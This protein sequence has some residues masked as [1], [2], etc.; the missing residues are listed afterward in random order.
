MITCDVAQEKLAET[1]AEALKEDDELRQHVESCEACSHVLESLQ[2]LDQELAQTPVV[3]APDDVVAKTLDAVREAAKKDTPTRKPVLPRRRIAGALAASVAII[4]AVGVTS[5]VMRSTNDMYAF[6]AP[7]DTAKTSTGS[8]G[9]S[10]LQ[11]RTSGGSKPDQESTPGRKV[12]IVRGLEAQSK[13]ATESAQGEFS[14]LAQAGPKPAFGDHSSADAPAESTVR[15]QGARAFNKNLER[16]YSA[17]EA[18]ANRR[19]VRENQERLERESQLIARL[20]PQEQNFE[21]EPGPQS[22]IMAA[23]APAT[24]PALKDALTGSRSKTDDDAQRRAGSEVD[25]V[26]SY[27]SPSTDEEQES[28]ASEA[29]KKSKG[30]SA[31]GGDYRTRDLSDDKTNLRGDH[32]VGNEGFA[33]QSEQ[34]AGGAVSRLEPSDSFALE[35]VG[36][37]AFQPELHPDQARQQAQAYLRSIETLEGLTYQDPRGYWSNTYIPGDSAMRLLESRLK[38]W[39]RGVLGTNLQLEQG[40]RQIEQ[41]FDAPQGAALAVYLDSDKSAIE[42]PTRLRLQVGLKAAEHQGGQRP[43]MNVALV[44]DS[45]RLAE[46]RVGT[47]LRALIA[48]LEEARQP[49]DRFYLIAD[50]PKGGLLVTPDQFRHGPLSL[51][52]ERL[53][54]PTSGAPTEAVGLNQA[55]N[56]AAQSVQQNDDPNA[57]LGS[58]LILLATGSDQMAGLDQ[59]E[60]LAHENAVKGTALSVVALGS[61]PD[62]DAIDR[63][64][65][66][67]QGNRRILGSGSEAT[68]LIDREL[69][70]ASR[71]VAR[72][73]RLRIRLAPGV[74]LVDVVG[75]ERLAAPQA[76]RVRE[77][78][79]A[80]DLNLSRTLGIQAD[81]GE[82]EEGIQIV[83]PNFYADDSHVVVLD[84]VAQKPGPIADVTLRYKDVIHLRNGVASAQ[85]SLPSGQSVRGPLQ[86]NVLKN[87]LAQHFAEQLRIAS[88]ALN[89]GHTSLAVGQ[90]AALRNLIHGLRL[91][92]AGWVNDPDLAADEALLS[93]YLTALDSPA[94][95]D[96]LQQQFLADSLRFAAFR[97][98]QEAAAR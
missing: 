84:V 77:A 68:H 80:I 63:L 53:F 93:D 7:A 75:S 61:R 76:Q 66:A 56:L 86:Q 87:L 20:A 42:G 25:E 44:V 27:E 4:A 49:G 29:E 88:R 26:F 59:L 37:G 40:A 31:L 82:D 94:A 38:A 18:F 79:Q 81:R 58:N 19:E 90:M 83:I 23:P 48:A 69:F 85:L 11:S 72:A 78:E 13:S 32:A 24:K 46:D 28:R 16:Q 51:A 33:S 1:G 6:K 41:P 39:D 55:I 97:K 89:A 9:L 95:D 5:H 60:R 30:Q 12:E 50:G 36:R 91:E 67:G 74:E 57:I 73:V 34:G 10:Q 47:G 45:K 3:D 70:A 64:V 71:A 62:L 14:E 65:A 35:D 54:D 17:S 21:P 8:Y 98:L 22:E 15:K 43:A 52:I 92:T 2:A 96:A